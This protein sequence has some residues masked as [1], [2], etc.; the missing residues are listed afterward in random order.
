MGA[1]NLINF[2]KWHNWIK[3]AKFA[4]I[5]VFNRPNYYKKSIIS[6]AAKK[7]NKKKWEYI[8]STKIEISSS[9]IKKI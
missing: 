1:D 3:I 9:K 7:F 2:H 8:S 4:K 6:V 5:I